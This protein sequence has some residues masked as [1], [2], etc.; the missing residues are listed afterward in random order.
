[1]AVEVLTYGFKLFVKFTPVLTK[2]FSLLLVYFD[3]FIFKF[4]VGF[5]G[6]HDVAGQV[7]YE[8]GVFGDYLKNFAY[9]VMELEGLKMLK[10]GDIVWRL[11]D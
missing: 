5:F 3:D 1:M 6:L 2:I 10:R 4:S 7:F 8:L 9:F 11:D